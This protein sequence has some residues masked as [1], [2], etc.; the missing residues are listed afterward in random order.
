MKLDIKEVKKY[1]NKANVKMFFDAVRNKNIEK[2]IKMMGK[3]MD[4]NIHEESTGG[5]TRP[6]PNFLQQ[7]CLAIFW[8]KQI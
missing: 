2:M 4:P 3:C 6:K 5:K 7:W 1:H 8:V